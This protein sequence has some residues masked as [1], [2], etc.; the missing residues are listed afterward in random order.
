MEKP[1][2]DVPTLSIPE[3]TRGRSAYRDVLDKFLASG[4]ET[5]RVL[6]D[7]AKTYPHGVAMALRGVKRK[8]HEDIR[9]VERQEN[10]Y[11]TTSTTRIPREEGKMRKYQG[12]VEKFL[13]ETEDDTRREEEWD[14]TDEFASMK[15]EALRAGVYAE[16]T[17][18][19][20]PIVI[21]QKR[22]R[23]YIRRSTETPQKTRPKK[24]Y[25]GLVESFLQSDADTCEVSYNTDTHTARQI[26]AGFRAEIK[27]RGHRVKVSRD[28]NTVRLHRHI[29]SN[30][31]Y[32]E[33]VEDFL[34]NS[35]QQAI[36][37]YDPFEQTATTTAMGLRMA[38][39][40]NG[41]EDVTVSVSNS[42]VWL[43]R[44]E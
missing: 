30:G 4:E 7:P 16:I 34:R 35:L 13:A 36:V 21:R 1:M 12:I 23:V 38:I 43:K 11:L 37:E 33:I 32:A 26:C 40:R 31:R 20:H 10:V 39:K 18:G 27:A 9:I 28:G 14:I 41:Y 2:E 24:W 44:E 17:H 42:T 15:P 25:R 29:E 5:C 6:Y 3:R 19:N 8:E 22:G